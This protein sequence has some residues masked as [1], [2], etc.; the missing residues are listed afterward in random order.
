[1]L[2]VTHHCHTDTIYSAYIFYSL[3]IY[4][5][6]Y[7]LQTLYGHKYHVYGLYILKYNIFVCVCVCM[8]VC[9]CACA[10]VC[11]RL[12]VYM[13]MCVCACVCVCVWVCGACVFVCV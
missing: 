6:I 9:V 4:I 3:Y 10:C 13:Y 1:M 12:C 2:T 11:V 7:N 8:C 5:F